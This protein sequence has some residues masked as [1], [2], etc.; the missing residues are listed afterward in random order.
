MALAK[1][2]KTISSFSADIFFFFHIKDLLICNQTEP[3][4]L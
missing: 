1:E 2:K 3:H 4:D